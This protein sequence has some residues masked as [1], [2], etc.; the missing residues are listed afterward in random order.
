MCRYGQLVIKFLSVI[1]NIQQDI[2]FRV[3]AHNHFYGPQLVLSKTC[4][5]KMKMPFCKTSQQRAGRKWLSLGS[6]ITGHSSF[7]SAALKCSSLD[8]TYFQR[9]TFVTHKSY[10]SSHKRKKQ[11]D[12][13]LLILVLLSF[14]TI[15]PRAQSCV[16]SLLIRAKRR[17]ADHTMQNSLQRAGKNEPESPHQSQRPGWEQVGGGASLFG[18]VPWIVM[19]NQVLLLS[20]QILL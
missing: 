10:Y 16:H 14:L 12:S 7:L 2:S 9:N 1:L 11:Q 4:K 19:C 5:L 13:S 17:K 15:D 3:W 20:Q 8:S 6:E 18:V